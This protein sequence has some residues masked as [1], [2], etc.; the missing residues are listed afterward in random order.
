[1]GK[2]DEITFSNSFCNIRTVIYDSEDIVH[3]VV[4]GSLTLSLIRYS[5]V[6]S[7]SIRLLAVHKKTDQKQGFFYKQS[8]SS[9]LNSKES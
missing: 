3:V 6:R 1:M 8:V 4:G 7:G 9:Y 5:A 2:S